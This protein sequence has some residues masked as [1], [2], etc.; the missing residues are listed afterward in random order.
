MTNCIKSRNVNA[1]VIFKF[2][3]KNSN[4]VCFKMFHKLEPG[5]RTLSE[6]T[7]S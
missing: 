7:K 2:K 6:E 4:F 1:V 5:G 3:I